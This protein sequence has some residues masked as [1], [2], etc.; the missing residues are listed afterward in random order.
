MPK[1]DIARAI[2]ALAGVPVA[3]PSANTSGKPSPTLAMHAY[4]DLC[5]RVTLSIDGGRARS[6]WNRP[7]VDVTGEIPVVLRPA[8]SRRK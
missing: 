8:T 4:E 6:A 5:G 1:N 2:I 7:W 3:A